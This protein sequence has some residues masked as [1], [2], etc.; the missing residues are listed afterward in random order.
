MSAD[1][2]L[3]LL[4]GLPRSGTTWIAKIF[5]SHPQTLYRHEP[6]SGG[7]LNDIPLVAPVD[8]AD[9]YRPL[10]Q[11]FVQNLPFLKSTKVSATLPIFRKNYYSPGSF[12]LYWIAVALAK[13]GAKAFGESPVPFLV[14]R[15]YISPLYVIWKS[16]ESVGRLGVIV[17]SVSNRRAVLILRHPCATVASVLRGE[18]ER[19]FGNTKPTSDDFGVFEALLTTPQAR[20]RG[21]SLETIKDMDPIERIA[22]RWILFN[23]KALEDIAGVEGCVHVRYEDICCDPRGKARELLDFAGLRWQP[24]TE[25]FINYSTSRNS[26]RYYSL[27]KDPQRAATSWRTHLSKDHQERVFRVLRQSRLA[28]LYPTDGDDCPFPPTG[29]VWKT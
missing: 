20:S 3:I 9:M 7:V 8:K 24:Q 29:E 15:S 27:F 13:A 22:W 12:F 18:A 25:G 10:I 21:F 16:I 17:R 6:D 23:E 2:P 28:E 11:T 4:F 14:G 1:H 5:D 26:D 19:Q